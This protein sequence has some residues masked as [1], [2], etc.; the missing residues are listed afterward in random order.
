MQNG[1]NYE[2]RFIKGRLHSAPLLLFLLA[3]MEKRALY[4]DLYGLRGDRAGRCARDLL[5]DLKASD[6][7]SAAGHR[8]TKPRRRDRQLS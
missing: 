1:D 5:A 4:A 6:E 8:R 3:G 2:K 7:Y